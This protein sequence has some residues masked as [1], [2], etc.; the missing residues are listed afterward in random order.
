[1]KLKNYLNEHLHV[2]FGMYFQK[3]YRLNAFLYDAGI[4]NCKA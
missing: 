2:I 3:N 4:N 1:M